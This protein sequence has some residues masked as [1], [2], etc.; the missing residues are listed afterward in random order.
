VPIV[1]KWH[2]IDPITSTEEVMDSATPPPRWGDIAGEVYSPLGLF[3]IANRL[4]THP[5]AAYIDLT[6][7][8]WPD[9]VLDDWYVPGST[10]FGSEVL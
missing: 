1:Q 9:A 2:Y 4:L 5:E 7:K 10:A 6:S 3:V 8:V